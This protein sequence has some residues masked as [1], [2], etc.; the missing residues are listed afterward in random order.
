MSAE[1]I[2]SIDGWLIVECDSRRI[3]RRVGST[4]DVTVERDL[5]AAP[6][7]YVTL[8]LTAAEIIYEP[9]KVARSLRGLIEAHR[10]RGERD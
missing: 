9:D 3:P 8:R 6:L 5:S 2:W 4:G 7:G 1:S 10:P